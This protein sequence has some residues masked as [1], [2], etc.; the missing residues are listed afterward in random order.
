MARDLLKI[1]NYLIRAG[2]LGLLLAAVGALAT[3][4]A[5]VAFEWA[6]PRWLMWVGLAA[7]IPLLAA[8]LLIRGKERRV[9]ALWHILETEPEVRVGDLVDS[10][11]LSRPFVREALALI[12]AQPGAF[13]V[14]NR[15]TDTIVHGRLRERSVAVST[16]ESCGG[17]VNAVYSLEGSVAPSCPYCGGAVLLGDWNARRREVLDSL[18]GEGQRRPFSVWL[19]IVLLLVFWPL[20]VAY[21][22]WISGLVDGWLEHWRE[23]QRG[24]F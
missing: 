16:C 11:G 19:F 20:A 12:N 14:W 24:R 7:A 1:D 17:K 9:D 21:A 5:P 13:F 2:W 8:G 3:P 10:T 15:E 23:W 22:L 6:G 18:R 4:Q